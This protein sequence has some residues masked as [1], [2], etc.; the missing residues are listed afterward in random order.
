MRVCSVG[1]RSIMSLNS[2]SSRDLSQTSIF[3][4]A[5]VLCSAS[6]MLTFTAYFA[7]VVALYL[8]P[9]TIS[10]PCIMEKKDLGPKPAIIGHRGAP[11]VSTF[12]L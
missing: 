11:M 9:L 8:V 12:I 2:R 5:F 7:V 4:A 6:Q 3:T 10:S 1:N